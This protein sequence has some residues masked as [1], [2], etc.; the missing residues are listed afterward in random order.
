MKPVIYVLQKST[1]FQMKIFVKKKKCIQN[2]SIL[3][4]E[5]KL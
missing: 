5:K 3:Q 2:I 4:V 1:T